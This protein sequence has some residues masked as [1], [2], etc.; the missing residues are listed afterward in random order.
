MT[1]RGQRRFHILLAFALWGTRSEATDSIRLVSTAIPMRDGVRLAATLYMPPA[2]AKGT[3]LPV[4]LEYLPYRKD[5]GTAAGDYPVHAYFARHGYVTARVDIRGTGSSEGRPPDREYSEQEQQDGEDV[6]DW[7]SHEP[8]STGS[9]GMFGISWGGFNALQLAMRKPKALKAIL[10]VDAT[11]ELFH[12]DIHFIDGLMHLDEFELYMDLAPGL[13]PAPDY[14]LDEAVLGPRFDT[15]PWSLLYLK[16]QRDGPF[17]RAPVRP[18]KDYTVPSFLIGGF[19]DG[20]RDS[21]VRM[22]EQAKAPIKAIL[23]PWNHAQPHDADF[24]PHI[25][26]RREAVRFWDHWLKGVSNGVEKD[27]RLAVFMREAFPPDPSLATIPGSWRAESAWPPAGQHEAVYYL[28]PTHAL[29]EAPPPPGTHSLK[30]VPSVGVEAGFWWGELLGDQRPVDAFSLVYDSEPLKE[31]LPILGR[32]HALLRAAASAPLADWFVRLEDVA[33]DGSVTQVTGA[34]LGGAQR[35]SMSEPRALEPGRVYPLDVALHVTS[36]VFPK[37]H[38]IRVAVSNALWPMIWPTPDPM[39]TSLELGTTE[40]SR[41]VLPVV[42]AEGK[43]PVTFAPPEASE[44]RG[45]IKTDH[46]AWPGEWTL[47]RDEEH[48]RAKVVWH[49]ESRSEYPWGGE[50]D[51]E[52][53]TSEVADSH[54]EANTVHGEAEWQYTVL[55][56]VIAFRGHLTLTSDRASFR[57]SYTREALRDGQLVRTKTW[58]ETVPR[59]FQ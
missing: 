26:W 16:N 38:S 23:G 41:L 8:F 57:Y 14:T 2:A 45:D 27:P 1:A 35:E 44:R 4:L 6:I 18:W 17:W 31:A 10:A 51:L 11:E 46:D 9:V 56:H 48:G 42:P 7:L 25:E 24:G 34:G 22:L 52:T 39:T 13:T 40:G 59:D 36:W 33:P 5:D 53:L 54:P 19:A 21:I 37:G 58:E 28:G 50:R 15:P 43:N 32:P 29:E 3:R 55:G 47:E 20:Y 12:D 30:Y 49:G